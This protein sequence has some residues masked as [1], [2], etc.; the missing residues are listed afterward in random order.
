MD[1]PKRKALNAT[2]NEKKNEGDAQVR[3][4]QILEAL[5]AK[6]VPNTP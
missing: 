4:I 3:L 2:I 1:C 6:S 5:K